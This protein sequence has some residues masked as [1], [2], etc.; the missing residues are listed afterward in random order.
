MSDKTTPVNNRQEN[1]HERLELIINATG[2][3][4]WDW[5]IQTDELTF[6]ERWAEII[7]YRYDE[8]HPIKF[9]T[10]ASYLHPD[11]LIRANELITQHFNGDLEFYEVEARI[12]HKSGHYVWV[13][14]SGKLVEWDMD[15]NPKRMIGFH[16]D[17]TERKKAEE[18][19]VLASQLLNESERIGKLG[20][21]EFNLKTGDLFW[22]E[23]TYRIH[24]TTPEEF[25]PTVDAGVDYFLPESKIVIAKALDEAIKNGVGYDL[26][27]ET[28]TT[29][30][31]KIDVRTTCT[32]SMED[33]VPVRL[34]GIFQD[35][36]EQKNNQ[37]KLEKV[38]VNCQLPI[39]H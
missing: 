6:N 13:Q 31:R 23:E 9:D 2:V 3:G 35:I 25:N 19:M 30:G 38:I 37:R 4:I 17:I 36:T 28:Y 12:K 1:D 24:E 22:T 8:L 33:G 39:Q 27:L 5:Q 14:A 21:W 16:L 29:K 20:G 10:W 18:S 32:V 34:V 26:E 11:D 15:G 7:G